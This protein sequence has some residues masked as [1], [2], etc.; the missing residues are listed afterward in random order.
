MNS[1]TYTILYLGDTKPQS[2]SFF[3]IKALERLGHNV[4][5]YN[6]ASQLKSA[7]QS[8]W[9]SKIHYHTGY[10]LLQGKVKQQLLKELTRIQ[11]KPDLVWVNSGELL[12]P[13]SMKV[14]KT[15][16]VPIVL[17][18]NDDPTGGRDGNRFKSLL[19]AI[20]YYDLCAVLRVQN[21]AEYKQKGA[22][23]V[24]RVLMSYDEIMHKPYEDLSEIPE[25]IKSEV[26]FIGT[27]MKN[28]NRDVFILELIKKGV[29]ISIRGDHWNKSPYFEQLKA[30]WKGPA[31]YGREY[32][33]AIQGAK[34]CLGFLSKGNRDLHTRRSVEV[35][36]I[37]SLFC[38]ERTSEHQEM[39][40]EGVEAVF[41]SSAEECANI[42]LD[43][44]QHP[45]KC[46]AIRLAGKQR[47]LQLHAGNEDIARLILNK[48]FNL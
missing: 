34:I 15:L 8:K 37:G 42:C 48:T 41:W 35:P 23:N 5:V 22:L 11:S 3:R 6:P 4:H 20:R 17:Y 16:N 24:L 1:K 38:A 45:A 31:V 18:N 28:E 39:Y 44:L 25:H 9:G 14:L 36:F 26:A 7:L 2:N 43:L 47:V 29:P 46:E 10:Q 19:K 40:A 13:A 27:W 12:G 32:V 33:T 21:V 30:Y